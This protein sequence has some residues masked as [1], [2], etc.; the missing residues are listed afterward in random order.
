M[1][2]YGFS[3][4]TY[5]VRKPSTPLL[6][7]NGAP[8]SAGESAETGNN[9]T[10]LA[11]QAGQVWACDGL[12]STRY[13]DTDAAPSGGVPILEHM[14]R[15][16]IPNIRTRPIGSGG[17][18]SSSTGDG[19]PYHLR[20][21]VG[22]AVSAAGTCAF[23]IIAGPDDAPVGGYAYTV[24]YGVATGTATLPANATVAS[25]SSTTEAWLSL[26]TNLLTIDPSLIAWRDLETRT[27]DGN[28]ATAQAPQLVVDVLGYTGTNGVK[29]R[30]FGLYIAE[31]VGA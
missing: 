3:E 11:D 1:A 25:T 14:A 20:V 8:V 9:L 10:H 31:Y 18:A 5:Y 7:A 4:Y 6:D 24:A 23:Y 22:G 16:K 2:Q 29:P 28:V 21:R 15:V 13:K 17:V 26:G 12:I 30:L 27:Y 19:G